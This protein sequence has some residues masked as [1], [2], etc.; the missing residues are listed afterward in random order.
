MEH[1]LRII[2][3]MS[4]ENFRKRASPLD[5]PESIENRWC[6]M[7]PPRTDLREYSG[8][9]QRYLIHRKSKRGDIVLYGRS[10]ELS[11]RGSQARELKLD[12]VESDGFFQLTLLV[13]EMR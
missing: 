10:I 13:G 8:D 5:R 12:T 9:Q 1:R 11:A 4:S 7:L 6:N 3:S 2:A